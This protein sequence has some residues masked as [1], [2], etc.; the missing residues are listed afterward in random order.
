[1]EQWAQHIFPVFLTQHWD[2][3]VKLSVIGC[4]FSARA[5][6]WPGSTGFTAIQTAIMMPSVLSCPSACTLCFVLMLMR[7][8]RINIQSTS[9][10]Y[11]P[12]T[13][14]QRYSEP[15]FAN[16]QWWI[17]S[18]TNL[19]VSHERSPDEDGA[20]FAIFV[21]LYT[22]PPALGNLFRCHCLSF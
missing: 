11:V 3:T 6:D 15:W 1:M 8:H 12:L 2:T 14:W 22:S 9:N 20:I 13:A 7:R 16:Q 10:T 21:K 4:L 18:K 5:R 17:A 19:T